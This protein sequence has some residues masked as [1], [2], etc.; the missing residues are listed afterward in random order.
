MEG[1]IG[2]T[3]TV[4]T[5]IAPDGKVSIHGEFWNAMSDQTIE[6]GEKV[7]VIGVVNLKL[8]VKKLE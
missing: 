2:E 6:A 4:S 7:Q 1:L 5:P 8:K 3:G